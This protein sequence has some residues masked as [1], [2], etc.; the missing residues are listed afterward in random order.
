MHRYSEEMSHPAD[1]YLHESLQDIDYC[2]L[3]SW[4]HMALQLD[5]HMAA[6]SLHQRSRGHILQWDVYTHDKISII[7][8]LL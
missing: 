7:N 3:Q 8:N 1:I 4:G 2:I 6:C 5:S